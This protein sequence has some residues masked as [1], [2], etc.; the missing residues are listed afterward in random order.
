MIR[1]PALRQ[2][3]TIDQNC[4]KAAIKVEVLQLPRRT[5]R[6]LVVAS[7]RLARWRKSSSLL[8]MMQPCSSAYGRLP[9]RALRLSRAPARAGNRNLAFA[10]VA[11]ELREVGYQPKTSRRL[12]HDVVSLIGGVVEGGEDIFAL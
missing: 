4:S 11:K 3:S 8:I 2:D 7:G 12:E 10:G 6:T 1:S 9:R 5:Q